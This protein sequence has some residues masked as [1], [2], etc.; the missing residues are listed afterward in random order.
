MFP[1]GEVFVISSVSR[2]KYETFMVTDSSD[3]AS[4][5]DS[6]LKSRIHPGTESRVEDPAPYPVTGSDPGEVT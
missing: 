4:A 2:L 5:R 3:E 1:E 6:D